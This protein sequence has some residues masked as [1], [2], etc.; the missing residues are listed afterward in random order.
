MTKEVKKL[1]DN[2]NLLYKKF[3][4]VTNA[5]THL[6]EDMIAFNKDYSEDLKVKTEKDDNV[7]EKVEEFLVDVKETISK[8]DPLTQSSIF[9]DSTFARVLNIVSSIKAE[10]AP[11]LNLAL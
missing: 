2:Y 6:I 5:T 1:D 8:V 10:L 9:Q 7:F 3:D 11:I 4:V